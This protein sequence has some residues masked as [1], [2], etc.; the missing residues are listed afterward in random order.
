M[1]HVLRLFYYGYNSGVIIEYF[2]Q[3]SFEVSEYLQ[4]LNIRLISL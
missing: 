3:V 2:T 1:D 4:L